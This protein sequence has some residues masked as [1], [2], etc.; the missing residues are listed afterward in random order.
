[1]DEESQ[2]EQFAKVVE[3]YFTR[4]PLGLRTQLSA[5]GPLYALIPP[6][7]YIHFGA[8][9]SESWR[10]ATVGLAAAA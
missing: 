1:M 3:R 5:S 8:L 6:A 7:F 10:S 4:L 2:H 9:G